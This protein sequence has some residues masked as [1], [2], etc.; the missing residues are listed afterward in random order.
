M[1]SP[2]PGDA[3]YIAPTPHLEIEHLSSAQPKREMLLAQL[4]NA[5]TILNGW[6]YLAQRSS[7]HTRQQIYLD[8]MQGTLQHITQLMQTYQHD[9]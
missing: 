2:H 6:A 5:L 8:I 7:S 9:R 4:A 1:M 3:Q